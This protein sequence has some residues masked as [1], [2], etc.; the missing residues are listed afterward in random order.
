MET[1]RRFIKVDPREISYLRYT[2]E[3]YDG[4][5]V[6]RTADPDAGILELMI[7]PGCEE[8]VD[9]L[10]KSFVEGERMNIDLF[11]DLSHQKASEEVP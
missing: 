8:F 4:M 9:H 2:I 5:A 1:T 6:V 11:I 10:L 3:S 7:A